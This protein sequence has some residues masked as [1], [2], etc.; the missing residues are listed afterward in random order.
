[1]LVNEA[2]YGLSLQRRT[3]VT[4]AVNLVIL[5]ASGD[6]THRLL[7]PGLGTL[8][9]AEHNLSVRLIGAGAEELDDTT[10]CEMVKASLTEGGCSTTEMQAILEDTRYSK[11]DAT[12]SKDLAGLM[13]GLAGRIVLY[14]ALP[15]AVSMAACKALADITLPDELY[16][17]IEKP[18]GTDAKSAHAFNELLAHLPL[19]ESHIFRVD[20]Y[21]GKA[22]VL[23]LVGL[24]FTNR[25]FEPVWNATNIESIQIVYDEQ[26]ALEGR[27]GYYDRA[28]ALKDMIQSHL[29]LVMALLC[30]EELATFDAFELR[31]LMAHL[32]RSTHLWQ[33]DPVKA[34][35]RARYT[36]GKVGDEVVPDYVNEPGVDPTRNTETLAEVV[37]EIRNARWTGVPI[38]LRSGKALGDGVRQV[39]VVFRPVAHTP[40]G[41]HEEAPRNVVVIGVS[42]EFIRVQLSTNAEG[43]RFSLE[44]SILDAELG[45]SQIRPYGE[46]LAHILDGDPLLSVRDDVAEDC[47]RIVTPVLDAWA[48]GKVP[49]DSYAAGSAGPGAWS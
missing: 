37:V 21:L 46:I 6:L 8:L 40:V 23:N 49:L 30:M 44:P 38:T 29:L 5:G 20:H 4:E 42:P 33:D 24:R 10:W 3:I 9:K 25:I 11:I 39:T 13:E 47:W 2:R 19:P 48:E 43:D 32:L 45:E 14:F 7:L 35:R 22:T 15:P 28:G 18:F 36:A 31:D 1:M 27:A 26:L 41:F 16:L 17:A 12:A 34:S